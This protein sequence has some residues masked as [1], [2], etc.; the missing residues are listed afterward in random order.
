MIQECSPGA[1]AQSQNHQQMD[2]VET[3]KV[4]SFLCQDLIHNTLLYPHCHSLEA[5]DKPGEPSCQGLLHLT[6][7]MPMMLGFGIQQRSPVGQ[8]AAQG[9]RGECFVSSHL[10]PQTRSL[11]GSIQLLSTLSWTNSPSHLI[12]PQT[13]I[14]SSRDSDNIYEKSWSLR[15]TKLPYC[16][17]FGVFASQIWLQ[18][19]WCLSIFGFLGPLMQTNLLVSTS[20]PLKALKYCHPGCCDLEKQDHSKI[21]EQSEDEPALP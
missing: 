15:W 5:Q 1:G 9:L 13:P 7:E 17:S 2:P 21:L 8:G 3:K 19:C 12:I 16:H 10:K 14:H 6:W 4:N 20:F 18:A 11:E